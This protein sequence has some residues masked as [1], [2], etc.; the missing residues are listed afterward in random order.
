[1]ALVLHGGTVGAAVEVGIVLG[2]ILIAYGLVASVEKDIPV[3]LRRRWIVLQV[4]LPVI[5]T[6][7]FL[8]KRYP[9]K[10]RP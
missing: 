7:W 4:V 5:G 1:M 3:A 2:A 8:T 9:D 6:L 10:P